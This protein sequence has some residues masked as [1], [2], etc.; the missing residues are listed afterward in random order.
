VRA[1]SQ[2]RYEEVANLIAGLVNSGTLSPGS[3]APSLRKISK[4]QQIIMVAHWRLQLA[5]VTA[6]ALEM[7]RA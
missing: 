4:Q 2:F 7:A 1:H 5:A 6:D 3:R